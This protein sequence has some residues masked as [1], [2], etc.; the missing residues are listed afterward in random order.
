MAC[1]RTARGRSARGNRLIRKSSAAAGAAGAALLSYFRRGG[2]ASMCQTAANSATSASS[3]AARGSTE[4]TWTAVSS[5]QVILLVGRRTRMPA[6]GRGRVPEL[7]EGG[8]GV[9]S[10]SRS[11]WIEHDTDLGRGRRMRCSRM[12]GSS[13]LDSG[14]YPERT[15]LVSCPGRARAADMTG[16]PLSRVG[17][18]DAATPLRSTNEPNSN[19]PFES[20]RRRVPVSCAGVPSVT[21][22]DDGSEAQRFFVV[23]YNGS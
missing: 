7:T 16:R 18:L 20:A 5:T 23:S 13:R 9:T 3:R 14:R 4:A 19:T 17:A 10:C 8:Q 11:Y 6:V 21:P 22:S 12:S 1:P 15:A 2:C